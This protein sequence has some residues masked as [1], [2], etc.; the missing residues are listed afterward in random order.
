MCGSFAA[1]APGFGVSQAALRL[2]VRISARFYLAVHHAVVVAVVAWL[3]GGT[4]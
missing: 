2:C 4:A 1:Y 3:P